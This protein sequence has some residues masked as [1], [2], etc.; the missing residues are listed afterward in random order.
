MGRLWCHHWSKEERQA[1]HRGLPGRNIFS[2]S[3]MSLPRSSHGLQGKDTT[4]LIMSSCLPKTGAGETDCTPG[5]LVQLKKERKKKE[6]WKKR[7]FP[8]G[9]HGSLC[10]V[11]ITEDGQTEREAPNWMSA[12]P[13][14]WDIQSC[15][16]AGLCGWQPT[17]F[18]CSQLFPHHRVLSPAVH[19]SQGR[20][21][22]TSFCFPPGS[23]V[24]G[25]LPPSPLPWCFRKA[26]IMWVVFR[27]WWDHT[28]H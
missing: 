8:P 3:W 12:S 24:I 16:I 27:K 2:S 14:G 7:E 17:L 18:A 28:G 5:L 25:L 1:G 23:D 13:T 19:S 6:N 4:Q 21:N 11:F 26:G 15:R 9:C 22:Y 20:F 10:N